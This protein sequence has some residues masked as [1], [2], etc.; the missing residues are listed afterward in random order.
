[1]HQN[2]APE[3]TSWL[4]MPAHVSYVLLVYD[5]NWRKLLTHAVCC[6]VR[7][8]QP[9]ASV[10]A[11]YVSCGPTKLINMHCATSLI[12][13]E[14]RHLHSLSDA[15]YGEVGNCC[16]NYNED[17]DYLWHSC[18]LWKQHWIYHRICTVPA[19]ASWFCFTVWTCCTELQMR[20]LSRGDRVMTMFDFPPLF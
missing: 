4:Y 8:C 1:M 19:V 9:R 7:N 11:G 18:M 3:M 16:G 13:E 17:S 14:S 5:G 2:V 15:F 12:A 10:D 20:A 6:R